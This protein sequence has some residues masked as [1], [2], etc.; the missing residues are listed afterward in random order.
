MLNNPEEFACQAGI[1]NRGVVQY[2]R[3]L[4]AVVR[5][6]VGARA[7]VRREART[8]FRNLR[9][10]PSAGEWVS[11]V[12][13]DSSGT[14]VSEGEPI[15][16]REEQRR[17]NKVAL[18]LAHTHVGLEASDIRDEIMGWKPH[19]TPKQH[20][21]EEAL[22]RR[23]LDPKLTA[24]ERDRI[25]RQIRRIYKSDEIEEQWT[26]LTRRALKVLR[27]LFPSADH[28]KEISTHL[29]LC[30]LCNRFFVPARMKRAQQYC[31]T[32]RAQWKTKQERW[33]RSGGKE[34]LRQWRAERKGTKEGLG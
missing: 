22:S 8:L 15:S 2:L 23:M 31:D 34:K 25:D 16:F 3:V 10:I 11:G 17:L 32:C 6:E 24:K 5:R 1:R 9:K 30:R 7:E 33:Y 28:T 19:L 14:W 13:W 29:R 4:S 21:R 12:G 27:R 20:A 18:S 26:H